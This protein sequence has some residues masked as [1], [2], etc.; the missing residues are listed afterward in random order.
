[1]SVWGHPLSVVGMCINIETSCTSQQVHVWSAC[2]HAVGLFILSQSLYSIHV[3]TDT[4]T[5]LPS[6]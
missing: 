2:F 6:L 1:V 3:E 5:V 4:L